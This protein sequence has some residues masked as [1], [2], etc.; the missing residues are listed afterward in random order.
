MKFRVMLYPK[1]SNCLIIIILLLLYRPN[2]LLVGMF[3]N[4]CNLLSSLNHTQIRKA[5]MTVLAIYYINFTK[6]LAQTRLYIMN[7]TNASIL[8]SQNTVTS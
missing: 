1:C 2:I 7:M 6:Q 8:S 3:Q 5:R 4:I